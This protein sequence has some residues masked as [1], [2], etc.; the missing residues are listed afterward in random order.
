MNLTFH[1]VLAKYMPPEERAEA[2]KRVSRHGLKS[3]EMDALLGALDY[4]ALTDL[5]SDHSAPR[6]ALLEW[7]AKTL[8]S[9]PKSNPRDRIRQLALQMP[10]QIPVADES[11]AV[12]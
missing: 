4:R 8:A 2:I 10:T 3:K 7:A 11:E 1:A 6:L 9:L 5:G 12:G